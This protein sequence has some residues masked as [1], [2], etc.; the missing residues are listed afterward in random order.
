MSTVSMTLACIGSAMGD[1]NNP[2]VNYS[3][4]ATYL[5]NP[6]SSSYDARIL[7][8]KFEPFPTALRRNKLIGAVVSA[9]YSGSKGQYASYSA[10]V[11][12]RG[13]ADFSE[14]SV[15]YANAPLL[16]G[17]CGYKHFYVSSG[18]SGWPSNPLSLPE[19]FIDS[20]DQ[21]AS[22]IL[23]ASCVSVSADIS[24]SVSNTFSMDGRLSSRKPSL[25]VQYDD[26][27]KVVYKPVASTFTSGWLNRYK[28]NEFKWTIKKADTAF[29][30]ADA[31]QE[32]AVFQWKLS[33]GSSWNEIPVPN[34]ALKLT[35]PAE[36]F[37][38]GSVN[39]RIVVID[40]LGDTLTSDTYTI[41]T[42]VGDLVAQPA[43]PINGAFMDPLG[44]IPFMWTLSNSHSITV[45]TGAD[46]Q[47]SADGTSWQTLGHVDGGSQTFNMPAGT[48]GAASYFWRVRAYNADGAAGPWSDSATFSTVD[49]QMNAV[50]LHPVSEICETNKPITFEWNCYSDTGTVQTRSDIQYSRDLNTWVDLPS[51]GSG[52]ASYTVPAD[53]FVAGTVYWRV[54]G[55]NHNDVAGPWSTNVSFIAFGAPG[56][57]SVS[58]DAVPFAI[59]RWQSSAQEA[60]KITVDGTEYGPYFGTEKHFEVPDYLRDGRHAVSV[61]VQGAYGLW[62]PPGEIVFDV[63]NEPTSPIALSA[64]FNRDAALSWEASDETSDF[65]VYRDG[66]KIGHATETT[67][68]DRVVLGRHEYKVINRLPSGYYSESNTV[69]GMLSMCT[70]ALAALEGGPW[71]E[72]RKS[73]NAARSVTYRE[74][75]QIALRQFAGQNYPQAEVSPYKTLSASFDVAWT[76]READLAADFAA[77]IGRTVI[78]KDPQEGVMVGILSAWERNNGHFYRAYSTTV[79]KTHW[80]DYIDADD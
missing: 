69:A 61:S 74:D 16:I 6:T 42:L 8:L 21:S 45:Q 63:A 34:N 31:V 72:L 68:E 13:V 28:N 51:T 53:F 57:P 54:R 60:Y 1:P 56:M 4:S 12:L 39:W 52:V 19:T 7:Y 46:L 55:Y 59:I 79:R 47:Y 29:C 65:F 77:L 17:S 70:L 32:S 24:G 43:S 30:A 9:Y 50:A 22:H 66:V 11:N 14:S 23:A 62:S 41:N 48:L 18:G 37:P 5:L 3:S 27:V 25:L 80:R 58:V 78:L 40:E 73:E 20:N 44:G 35:V 71:I 2:N 15:T 36:T 67:F 26:A 75:Q 38:G 49:A 33:T 10:T 64:F 76:N